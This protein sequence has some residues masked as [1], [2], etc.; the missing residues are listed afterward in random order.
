MA[1]SRGA[2]RAVAQEAAVPR[3]TYLVGRLN[4][5]LRR[6]LTETLIPFKLSVAQYTTL[7]V[8]HTRGFLS[9]AQLAKRA[10]ISPQAMNEVMQGLEARKLVARR[11]SESHGRI[12]QLLLTPKGLEM[13]HECD[14]AVYRLEQSMLAGLT[15]AESKLLRTALLTSAH[16][17]EHQGS[18]AGTDTASVSAG[19][20]E[21]EPESTH[22]S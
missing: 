22:W 11:A 14:A 8:L 16:A 6:R 20:R 17:L 18:A 9:N 15:V 12:V 5:A 19:I 10:F 1:N 21:G 4:R 7:S 13:M 2:R 3:M